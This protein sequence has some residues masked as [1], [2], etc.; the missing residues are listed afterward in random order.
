MQHKEG[1]PGQLYGGLET[2]LRFMFDALK[3]TELSSLHPFRAFLKANFS[4]APKALW[5]LEVSS[6]LPPTHSPL[7]LGPVAA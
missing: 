3:W 5:V 6:C 7:E 4:P 2:S 1:D